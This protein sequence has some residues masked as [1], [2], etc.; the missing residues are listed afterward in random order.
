MDPLPV[1]SEHFTLEDDLDPKWAV[2]AHTIVKEPS[3][4]EEAGA[5]V[6][7]VKEKVKEKFPNANIDGIL[8]EKHI[9]R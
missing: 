9:T 2:L 6:K 5:K 4:T 1:K 3:D 8:T 7:E